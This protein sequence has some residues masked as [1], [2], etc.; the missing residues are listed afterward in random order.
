V[1]VGALVAVAHIHPHV[2]PLAAPAAALQRYVLE[3]MCSVD[4]ADR[5]GWRSGQEEGHRIR[6]Q[7]G[8]RTDSIVLGSTAMAVGLPGTEPLRGGGHS[9]QG[10]RAVAAVAALLSDWIRWRFSQRAFLGSWKSFLFTVRHRGWGKRRTGGAD[11]GGV[12]YLHFH[13]RSQ[14]KSAKH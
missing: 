7:L 6:G 5:A 4:L 9:Q 8:S 10:R 14:E 3:D 2:D 13:I 11:G 12:G 1:A